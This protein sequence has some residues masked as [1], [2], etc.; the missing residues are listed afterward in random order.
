ML[1]DVFDQFVAGP[2]SPVRLIQHSEVFKGW[3]ASNIK[4][5]EPDLQAV[6]AHAHVKDLRYAPHRFESASAPLARIVLFFHAFLSTVVQI[7]AD[8]A[9]TEEGRNMQRFL[10][11]L[12]LERCLLVA[13]L[14]D[15]SH[16]TLAL[17]RM[18]DYQG[19]PCDELASRVQGYKDRVR[20]LFMGSQPLC[21]ETGFTNHMLKILKRECVFNLPA[22]RHQA[23]ACVKLGS[24]AGAPGALVD[25]CLERLRAWS[26]IEEQTLDAEFPCFDVQNA[27]A[28]FTVSGT[29]RPSDSEKHDRRIRQS[30]HISRLQR[31]FHIPDDTA[32]TEQLR[33][34]RPL[35]ARIA[36]EEGKGSVEAWM[37]A[38]RRATRTWNKPDVS[39]LLPL[40]VRMWASGAS[41]SAVEQAFGKS[42]HLTENLLLSS[43]VTDV[44]E[45]GKTHD[46]PE[47]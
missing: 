43:H 6:R 39:A 23:P 2:G 11:W 19:F 34:F 16:E 3:F 33:R 31:A 47:S 28:V 21:L 9:G 7:A 26:L 15:A 36:A 40:L 30:S 1:H 38:M 46:Q 20:Q 12:S 44:M 10:Q 17:I 14:A 32:A 42:K 5:L 27:F 8:R 18:L 29:E 37:E 25:S 13:M 35:A 24:A 41:T 22:G 4:N 45:A